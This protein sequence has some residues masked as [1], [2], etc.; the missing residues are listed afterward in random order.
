MTGREAAAYIIA[1]GYEE[2]PLVIYIDGK[3]IPIW[4]IC[5]ELG[6]KELVILPDYPTIEEN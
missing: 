6:K 2:K 1:N 3:A 5:Y 4:D